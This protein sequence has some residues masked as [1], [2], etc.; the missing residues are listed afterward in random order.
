[1]LLSVEDDFVSH[2]VTKN[3]V[4]IDHPE[5]MIWNNGRD[6]TYRFLTDFI[7]EHRLKMINFGID[8]DQKIV[9]TFKTKT[10]A[11]QF[12]ILWRGWEQ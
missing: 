4:I 5:F 6:L 3:S 7:K 1:M 12:K 11:A 10:D 9:V 2:P 8:K